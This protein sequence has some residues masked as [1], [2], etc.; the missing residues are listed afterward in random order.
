M[1]GSAKSPRQLRDARELGAT[2]VLHGT[3]SRF[4]VKDRTQLVWCVHP[5][6]LKG[7]N[8]TCR[9]QHAIQPGRQQPA[10]SLNVEGHHSYAGGFRQRAR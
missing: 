6:T 9:R 8:T 2:G 7:A 3:R 1:E 4:R 5:R 10:S